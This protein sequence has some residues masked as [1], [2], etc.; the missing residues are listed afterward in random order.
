MEGFRTSLLHAILACDWVHE[1]PVQ[2]CQ[3]SQEDC[4]FDPAFVLAG[5]ML[6]G[7]TPPS[8]CRS[9]ALSKHMNPSDRR[10]SGFF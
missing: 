3:A 4:G 10:F 9:T 2:T 1:R 6:I 7:H 8:P 5:C